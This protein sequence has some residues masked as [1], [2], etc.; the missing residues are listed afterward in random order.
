MANAE[1]WK[2]E[3]S[4]I[5]RSCGQGTRDKLLTHIAKLLPLVPFGKP[6]ATKVALN[7][8]CMINDNKCKPKVRQQI[9]TLNYITIECDTNIDGTL[10]KYGTKVRVRID[11]HSPD[12]MMVTGIK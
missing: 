5:G 4:E 12:Q 8:S 3:D 11:N 2:L 7:K 6:K 1:Q 9:K 10:V